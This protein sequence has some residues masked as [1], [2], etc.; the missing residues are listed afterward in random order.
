M[1]TRKLRL[2]KY[3]WRPDKPDHRDL[4][5]AAP[6]HLEHAL[7]PKTDLRPGC[8]APYDQGDL[9]S[10]TG[11]SISGLIQYDLIKQDPT[12]AFQPSALFIYYNERV[13]EN[14]INEDAGAE[15]RDG[16]KTLI[17]W[18]VCPEQYWPYVIA[19]FKT[20]P[21]KFAY[22]SAVPHRISQY[23]RINQFA[24]DMKSCLADGHPFVFGI[25]VYESFESEEVAKTGVVPMPGKNERMLGGHAICCVGYD[26][27]EQRFLIRN[28]WGSDWGM[29]GYFT[30]PYDYV[31]NPDLSSDFW[32]IRFV[33]N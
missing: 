26:D 9:G 14:S 23:M 19:K 16:I 30:I 15:I 28:S 6:K 4:K 29:G 7:P 24:N 22:N 13:L 33:P 2:H 25:A 18:G 12:K 10:C 31:L 8:P 1:A 20:K 3:G 21:S 11:Q 5:F 17:R 27:A 32:T